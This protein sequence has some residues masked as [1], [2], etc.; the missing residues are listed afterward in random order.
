M[1]I[2]VANRKSPASDN[3][4]PRVKQVKNIAQKLKL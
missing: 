4:I 2:S 3:L 1:E